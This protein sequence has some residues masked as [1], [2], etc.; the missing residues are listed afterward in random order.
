MALEPLEFSGT[1]RSV[2]QLTSADREMG[3]VLKETGDDQKTLAALP[4]LNQFIQSHPDYGD[5]YSLRAYITMCLAPRPN[6]EEVKS[7][8]DAAQSHGGR[9][10][11]E[12]DSLSILG[13]LAFLKG[14]YATALADLEK[15]AEADFSSAGKIFGIE[16]VKPAMEGKPCTWTLADLDRL[17]TAFPHDW[18]P[19]ALRGLYYQFFTT[20]SEEYYPDARAQFEKAA[21]LAPTNAVPQYLLGE[22]QMK[23]SFWT[24]KAWSSD[25][26]RD[27]SYRSAIVFYTKAI[28]LNP[29]Y[30][31]AYAARAEAYLNLKRNTLAIK[32][33][34]KVLQLD[35]DNGTAHADRGVAEQDDGQLYRAISDFG[36]ALRLEKDDGDF[37]PNLYEYRGDAYVGTRNYRS[38]IEDYS[39]AITKR[40]DQ[41]IILLSL[42]Q[43]RALYP[44]V[45]EMPDATLLRKL[46]THFAPQFETWTFDKLLTE[47]NKGWQPTL[48]RDLYQ[49]RGV[50]Y[51]KM[52]NYRRGILD[53]RRIYVGF[54]DSAD[55]TERWRTIGSAQSGKTYAIDVRRSEV[56][57]SKPV[58]LWVKETE[59]RGSSNVIAF[60]I[61]CNSEKI[62]TDSSVSYNAGGGV[63][64]SSDYSSGWSS[65]VPDSIGEQL[66]NGVC[67]E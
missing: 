7:D 47:Q 3:E 40:L 24:K 57:P 31:P 56:L 67:V 4:L 65:V 23:S 52:G 30:E 21:L 1:P 16:G 59:V 35:P 20:F 8:I 18:R 10:F 51:L 32:D 37:V 5:A 41:E 55:F 58:Q 34:D 22:L 33:F 2:P 48:L 60:G 29:T 62:R 54:P 45:S 43:I 50:A 64:G 27:Q 19:I 25:A 49:K 63:S 9:F 46:N 14:D 12:R 53:F 26:A 28:T 15:A 17:S 42:R 61:D 13:K 11:D 39:T 66:W 44:E 38:A 6:L 36:D